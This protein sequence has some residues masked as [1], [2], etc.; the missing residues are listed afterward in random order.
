MTL[1]VQYC[2][3][4]FIIIIDIMMKGD[5]HGFLDS[6][7]VDPTNSTKSNAGIIYSCG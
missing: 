1:C 5:F 3:S 2:L 6:P 4:L 7:L